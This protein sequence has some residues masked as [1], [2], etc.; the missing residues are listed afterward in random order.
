MVCLWLCS[1]PHLYQRQ[2]FGEKRL[3]LRLPAAPWFER[4]ISEN[5]IECSGTRPRDCITHPF[6][7]TGLVMLEIGEPYD[8]PL[9]AWSRECFLQHEYYLRP[10]DAFS[11]RVSA[12]FKL[13][14]AVPVFDK[15]GSRGRVARV[16]PSDGLFH[17]CAFDVSAAGELVGHEVQRTAST[18]QP[19]QQCVSSVLAQ[20]GQREEDFMAVM[21]VEP[22][23]HLIMLGAWADIVF[24]A[25]WPGCL[26]LVED[27]P[28]DHVR[29]AK[30]QQEAPQDSI[31]DLAAFSNLI[32]D[33]AARYSS[34]QVARQVWP[35]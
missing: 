20:W 25:R 9:S 29:R 27:F 15:I 2:G 19:A 22:L 6:H 31:V 33:A 3:R 35:A 10:L 23:A 18:G 34:P 16:Q 32:Q 8:G 12:A 7:L 14:D 4:V 11:L 28:P 30:G 1:V 13:A 21:L 17:P 24:L 5:A 26:H